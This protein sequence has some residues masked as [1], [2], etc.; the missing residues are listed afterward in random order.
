MFA[1]LG[2]I[3]YILLIEQGWKLT[4][5]CCEIQ[6][7]PA[8]IR[9]LSAAYR[10]YAITKSAVWIWFRSTASP[11]LWIS[12]CY[13]GDAHWVNAKRNLGFCICRIK[14]HSF[15]RFVLGDDRNDPHWWYSA[16][17]YQVKGIKAQNHRKCESWPLSLNTT[18]Y[19]SNWRK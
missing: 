4:F 16:Y 19:V 2:C 18:K 8:N 14:S 7:I 3:S 15:V 9:R 1:G 17:L 11:I 6:L 10:S 12:L 5:K 13:H